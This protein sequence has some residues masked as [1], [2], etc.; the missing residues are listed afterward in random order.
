MKNKRYM[1]LV[2]AMLM[3]VCVLTT[4][5]GRTV[6]KP[7]KTS[8]PRPTEAKEEESIRVTPDTGKKPGREMDSEEIA[9]YL[10]TRVVKVESSDGIGS[11]FFID[12]EGTIVT[13]YHV[14][15]GTVSI[16]VVMHDGAT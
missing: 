9:E 6:S 8:G 1:A 2:L 10:Q 13:N 16:K 11:G 7:G 12:D 3:L 5:C 15:D 14:I 4:G